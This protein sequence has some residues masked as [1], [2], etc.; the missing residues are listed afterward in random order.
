VVKREDLVEL[1]QVASA[2]AAAELT[3]MMSNVVRDGTGTAAA[4]SDLNV[5]AAGKTGTA[6]TGN[7][8]L[9]QAWFIGFAPA[10]DP[11]V[12]V[13]VVIEGTPS[14]GGTVAAPIAA[15]V[16]SAVLRPPTEEDETP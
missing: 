9:N 4:L 14:T 13:A 8:G 5:Q 10:E 1:G 3:D 2:T 15:D 16:M 7:A 6:E 11:V 12:A